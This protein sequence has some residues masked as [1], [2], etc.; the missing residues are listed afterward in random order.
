MKP[1]WK[2]CRLL[3]GIDDFGNMQDRSFLIRRLARPISLRIV[4]CFFEMRMIL[5]I[6]F[7]CFSTT[8][9]YTLHGNIHSSISHTRTQFSLL[10]HFCIISMT[11]LKK[12]LHT[13]ITRPRDVLSFLFPGKTSYSQSGED[14]ILDFLFRHKR[15][16]FY[17][18]VWAN[19]PSRLSNTF[20]FYNQRGWKGINIEPNPTLYKKFLVSRKRD[21]NLNLWIAKTTGTLEFFE[22]VPDTL[23]TFDS[24]ATQDYVDQWHTIHNTYQVSVD[25]LEHILGK[26]VDTNDSIDFL[27]VDTEWFDM[28]VLESNNWQ[29]YRPKAIVLETL[30]YKKEG[31]WKKLTR[32]FWDF[33]SEQKYY[34]Y[35]DT[36]INSIYVS[37]EFA[38]EIWFL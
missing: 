34:L 21:H 12:N 31:W 16:G 10:S 36:Y 5:V 15:N 14:M 3:S 38:Q 24:R 32:E 6:I 23:S 19:H 26:Q 13:I 35:A 2:M 22:I 18:D 33:L 37:E 1:G 28:E 7:V 17:V 8:S 27:S 11:S 25:S 9:L 4:G 30:E 29:K 20:F